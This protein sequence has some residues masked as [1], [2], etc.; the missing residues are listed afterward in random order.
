MNFTS[1][2]T[3]SATDLHMPFNS[4]QLSNTGFAES[5]GAAAD[6]LRMQYG[7]S[8]L[9]GSSLGEQQQFIRQTQLPTGAQSFYDV[10]RKRYKSVT[11]R[12]VSDFGAENWVALSIFLPETTDVTRFELTTIESLPYAFKSY[13]AC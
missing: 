10:A 11:H 1:Y 2:G 3:H 4:T 8:T 9:V 5:S 6:L 7:Q 12:I 13:G